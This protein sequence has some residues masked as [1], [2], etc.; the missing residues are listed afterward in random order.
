MKLYVRL[1]VCVYRMCVCGRLH[2]ALPAVRVRHTAP[3]SRHL[4]RR[5]GVEWVHRTS[6]RF[7]RAQRSRAAAVHTHP[8]RPPRGCWGLL[9][10]VRCADA[11]S[12]LLLTCTPVRVRARFCLVKFVTVIVLLLVSLSISAHTSNQQCA[13]C[14][15]LIAQYHDEA[16]VFLQ[17]RNQKMA[18]ASCPESVVSALR[19]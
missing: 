18:R 16:I 15:S 7:L 2:A 6:G 9:H 5:A 8:I 1:F 11:Y 13:T 14:S 4:L 17:A 19:L 3:V 10:T 12:I